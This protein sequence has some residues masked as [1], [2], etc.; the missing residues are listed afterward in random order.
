MSKLVE[1]FLQYGIIMIIL[2]ALAVLGIFV[3]KALR[4]RKDAKNKTEE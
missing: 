2:A 3:G 4:K 1:S